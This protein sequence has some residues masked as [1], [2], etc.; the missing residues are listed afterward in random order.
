MWWNT[1]VTRWNPWAELERMHQ[2]MDRLYGASPWSSTPGDGVLPPV[3]VRIADDAALMTAEIP[4]VSSDQVEITVEDRVVTIKGQRPEEAKPEGAEW[5]R[6]ERPQGEFSRSFALP[7]RVEPGDV[8][9]NV[10]D[11]V[12]TL[13]LPKAKEERPRRIAVNAA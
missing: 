1:G 6:R 2:A 7:F 3:N 4:G 13:R 5:L 8:T 10:R 11:G 12:L 9:A